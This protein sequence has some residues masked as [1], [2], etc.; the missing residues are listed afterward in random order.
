MAWRFCDPERLA[1]NNTILSDDVIPS[2]TISNNQLLF[3][4]PSTQ[5]VEDLVAVPYSH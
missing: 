5:R 4:K 1:V 3:N 2:F